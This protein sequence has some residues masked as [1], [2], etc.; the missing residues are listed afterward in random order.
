MR[1]IEATRAA[2]RPGWEEPASAQ[3]VD[4]GAGQASTSFALPALASGPGLKPTRAPNQNNSWPVGPGQ[5]TSGPG[6]HSSVPQTILHLRCLV[7][8]GSIP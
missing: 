5:G 4:P 8:P 7:T 2:R 1:L 3:D 6:I